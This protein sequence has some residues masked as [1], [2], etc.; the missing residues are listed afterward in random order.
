MNSARL[1]TSESVARGHPD[2]VCDQI[3]DAILDAYLTVDPMARVA[4][5]VLVTA[6]LVV[7]AGE[8]RSS[9]EARLAVD[10]ETIARGLIRD[11]GY[12]DPD[13][14]FDH[15]TCE[16]IDR[17]GRQSSDIALGVDLGGGALGAGDQGLM[18]GLAC[19]ETPELM[20]APIAYAHALMR[21]L[22]HVREN[23][24]LDWLR[25][26][27]KGQ[28]TVRYDGGR[29]AE[30]ATVVLSAQHAP[31]PK[32]DVIREGLVEEVIKKSIPAELLTA[33]TKFLVNPTGRFV[34]GGPRADAGLTG[35]KIIVDTYGG[36]GRHG[37]GAF[38]GKDPTKVDRSGAY[39]ARH[40]AKNI[41]AARLARRCEVQVAYAIGVPEPVSIDLETFGTAMA[42]V[43]LD[44]LE[45]LVRRLFPLT[46]AD[47]ISRF[48][49]R[50]PIF[51]PTATYGHFGR[52]DLPW[53]DTE[54]SS[55]LGEAFGLDADGDES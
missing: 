28:V 21:R 37:G 3:S 25:P 19:D 53:E 1:F 39:A 16:I 49:L 48:D 46:P 8:V 20:P 44:E 43:N 27:G 50:R 7:I 15:A 30:V 54:A 18:F 2:K 14:G 45:A 55:A 26:D 6:G 10:V 32:N 23:G 17:L 31:E 38:S 36:A 9:T 22:D 47:V 12:D 29:P 41:V 11:I 5:E 4:A 13:L 24:V 40:L 51:R 42:G 33:N 52:P 34:D 35:R